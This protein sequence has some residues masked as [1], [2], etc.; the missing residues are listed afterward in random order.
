MDGLKRFLCTEMERLGGRQHAPDVDAES[1]ETPLPYPPGDLVDG[2][3][4]WTWGRRIHMVP[5]GWQL[6]LGNTSMIFN[7]FCVGDASKKIRPYRFLRTFG[8]VATEDSVGKEMPLVLSPDRRKELLR[9][10]TLTLRSYLSQAH[11]VMILIEKHAG[12]KMKDMADLT[13]RAREAKF[14]QAFHQLCSRLHP[15]LTDEEL[16]AKRMGDRSFTTIYSLL[17]K[18]GLL[19]KTLGKRKARANPT[20]HENETTRRT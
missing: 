8:L 13:A 4:Q 11:D 18:K 2:Y 9:S 20:A 7:L 15:E 19:R 3:L 10:K 5:E 14:V 1:D 12:M 17:S 6:P 16:D